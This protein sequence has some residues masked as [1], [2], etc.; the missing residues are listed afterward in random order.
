MIMSLLYKDN[1]LRE[2]LKKL[3]ILINKKEISLSN[4]IKKFN[5]TLSSSKNIEK[6]QMLKIKRFYDV[7][8]LEKYEIINIKAKDVVYKI[9]NLLNLHCQ[10]KG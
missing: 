3:S 9:N 5:N 7:T 8:Y 6:E 4:D 2:K 1:S 10:T